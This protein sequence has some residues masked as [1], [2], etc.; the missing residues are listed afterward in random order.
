MT[1]TITAGVTRVAELEV[2]L[3]EVVLLCE[4]LWEAY[5]SQAAMEIE[6]DLEDH[7]E[8]TIERAEVVLNGE[9]EEVE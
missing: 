4:E 1:D 2:A 8:D 7:Y 3:E 6:T 9:Y 5:T